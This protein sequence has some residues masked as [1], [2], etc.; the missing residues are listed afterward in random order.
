MSEKPI[1]PTDGCSRPVRK[2]GLCDTCYCRIRRTGGELPP[3]PDRFWPRVDRSSG[4]DACWPWIGTMESTGNGYGVGSPHRKAYEKTVGPIP[5]GLELDHVCHTV[6]LKCPGGDICM[7]RRCCNPRHLEPVTPAENVRRM[8]AR[9]TSC[10]Q[11]HP[12]T[13]G[14]I[15]WYGGARCCRQCNR[16]KARAN[17]DKVRVG[18]KPRKT[19]CI[20]GHLLDDANSTPRSDGGR[21]C[22][23]C[24]REI[25]A[26]RPYGKQKQEAS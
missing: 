25:Y 10:P 6:D 15:Y 17:Y 5:E 7:H 26:K 14:N 19:H 24:Y 1:C 4:H 20:R 18:P 2:R 16:D 9:R 13:E 11:G 21:N 12:W 22:K 23:T 3:I 8:A